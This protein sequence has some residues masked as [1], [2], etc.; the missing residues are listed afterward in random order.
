M[1]G[2]GVGGYTVYNFDRTEYIVNRDAQQLSFINDL[3]H[4]Q[5]RDLF[6]SIAERHEAGE[7]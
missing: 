2:E 4:A 3:W 1:G 5:V 7:F 6:K